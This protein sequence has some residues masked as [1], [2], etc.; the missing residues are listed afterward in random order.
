MT[1]YLTKNS[2]QTDLTDLDLSN[3]DQLIEDSQ[4]SPS[5]A[6]T[7]FEEGYIASEWKAHRSTI[8]NSERI[9]WA[10]PMLKKDRQE[11]EK[12]G[13]EVYEEVTAHPSHYFVA[14]RGIPVKAQYGFAMRDSEGKSICQTTA[15]INKTFDPAIVKS[16]SLPLEV[17]IT[18]IH[19]SKKAPHELTY[20]LEDR[21]HI[22]LYGSRPPIGESEET[23]TEKRTCQE[24]VLAGQ[25]YEGTLAEFVDN[26]SKIN[27]CRMQGEV[28][29]AVFQLGIL[30]P[31]NALSGGAPEVKWVS[32]AEANLKQ[33]LDNGTIIPITA[34]FILRLRSMGKMQHQS[35]GDGD[36]QQAII[37]SKTYLPQEIYSWGD[38][39][40]Y[41]NTSR[42][43]RGEVRRLNLGG[44]TVYPVVTELYVAKLKNANVAGTHMP[45][46]S[47]VKDPEVIAA[48]YDV[49][50][51][52]WLTTALQA[53]QFETAV[54]EGR[55]ELSPPCFEGEVIAGVKEA[56]TEQLAPA[57]TTDKLPNRFVK[58]KFA[59]FS[60]PN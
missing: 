11:L 15:M 40:K 37:R 31:S 19:K 24:C 58:S 29:F 42:L 32:I 45:V 8:I 6:M 10:W 59:A 47:P 2:T 13:E 22:E 44:N 16:G 39:F 18:Q 53:L 48:G 46:F 27:K 33:K 34:P 14:L 21:P 57:D 55:S 50:P 7:E 28:L 38:Y 4:S 35:L 26:N 36:Y 41:L 52:D 3:L 30:D 25:H 43:P 9:K 20:W 51:K 56:A 17:P 5:L 60:N 23:T 12:A 54:N 49:T 1:S